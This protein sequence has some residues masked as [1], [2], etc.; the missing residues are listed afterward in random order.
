[1]QMGVDFLVGEDYWNFLGGENTLRDLLNIFDNVGKKWRDKI[2]AKIEE[3][4]KEKMEN[5]Q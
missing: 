1:M 5:Y 4:A 2:L 3:V